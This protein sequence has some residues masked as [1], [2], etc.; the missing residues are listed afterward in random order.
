MTE[1]ELYHE[2]DKGFRSII[3]DGFPY[4]FT[5][6]E[7]PSTPGIADINCCIDGHEFWIEGKIDNNILNSMQISW[8]KQR[9][10]AG[11]KVYIINY[12]NPT[13]IIFQLNDVMSASTSL[14]LRDCLM[15]I[16]HDIGVI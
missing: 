2:I 3:A 8:Q 6:I 1:T 7:S 10:N 14:Y 13:Y 5:R 16:L 4:H 12:K 9:I 15:Y 11:G